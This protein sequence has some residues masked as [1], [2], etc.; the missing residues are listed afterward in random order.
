MPL[1]VNVRRLLS[2]GGVEAEGVSRLVMHGRHGRDPGRGP[3]PAA[4]HALRERFEGMHG[5]SIYEPREASLQPD[6]A[7]LAERYEAFRAV[8]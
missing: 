5:A 8:S 3:L 7:R 1:D 2:I 6:R 4:Y